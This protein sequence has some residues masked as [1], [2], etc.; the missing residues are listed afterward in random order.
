LKRASAAFKAFKKLDACG[1]CPKFELK[2]SEWVLN[3]LIGVR[4][5]QWNSERKELGGRNS[6]EIPER[7]VLTC[8]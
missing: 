4:E 3:R 1:W 8:G 2:C 5:N 7:L 6:D